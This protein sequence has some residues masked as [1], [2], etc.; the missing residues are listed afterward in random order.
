M[1]PVAKPDAAGINALNHFNV[2][3][4]HEERDPNAF[5]DTSFNFAVNRDHH[6]LHGVR[7]G[8]EIAVRAAVRVRRRADLENLLGLRRI[9]EDDADQQHDDE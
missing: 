4:S 2:F 3:G 8:V 5:F 9:R 6:A 1:G 7:L